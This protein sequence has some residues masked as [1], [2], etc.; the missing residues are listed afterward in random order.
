MQHTIAFQESLGFCD[1]EKNEER[2]HSPLK[3]KI[4]VNIIHLLNINA[5][6]LMKF[7]LKINRAVNN[8]KFLALS[9][10]HK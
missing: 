6:Q 10:S 3:L 7:T 9:L 2:S 4:K 5:V 8:V 1:V